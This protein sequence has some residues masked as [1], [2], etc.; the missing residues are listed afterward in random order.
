MAVVGQADELGRVR[1]AQVRALQR[2]DEGV[3]DRIGGD[4]QHHDHRRGDQHVREAPLAAGTLGDPGAPPGRRGGSENCNYSGAHNNAPEPRADL[5]W[6]RSW[7]T[8]VNGLTELGGDSVF[9]MASE[10]SE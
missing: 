4:E 10:T 8:A 1:E 3:D 9:W 7:L 6:L 2:E 5:I